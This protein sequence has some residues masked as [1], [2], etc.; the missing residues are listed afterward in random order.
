M[1]DFLYVDI[2][3][4]GGGASGLISGISAARYAKSKNRSQKIIIIE[5]ENRVGK[6]LLL[7]GNGKCNLTNKNVSYKFY[8]SNSSEIITS[9]LN[10]F[11]V[12]FI[13]DFF[14]S[15]GLIFKEDD[16]GRIYP[17]CNQ[18]SA[19]LDVIRSEVQRLKIEEF[20]EIDVF[21]IYK[22]KDYFI[23]D[24][25]DI[26]IKSKIIIMATGGKASQIS[27]N[28]NKI[29]TYMENLGHSINTI[30][31]SL[32]Q[33]RIDSLFL[34]S[35]KGMRHYGKVSVIADDNI[36]KSETGE[37]QFTENGLSGICIFS[38][39]RIISEYFVT[40]KI[41]NKFYTNI[42]VSV[43]LLPQYS[44]LDLEDMM[45]NRF[46]IKS[47]SSLEDF[48]TGA[49]NK[50]IALTFLKSIDITPLSKKAGC[51]TDTEKDK[52][53]FSLKNWIFKPTGTMPW[54]NAQVTAGGIDVR[55]FNVKT[56][57][58]KKVKGLFA[59][60]EI[61]DVDGDCGGFNLHWAWSSGC[62]AGMNAAKSNL[63]E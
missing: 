10:T 27:C 17:Y 18:A 19:V 38:I 15:L 26:K 48:F 7:T 20:C 51:L 57:E 29:Y 58:S 8:N 6:K 30:F 1:D 25:A 49:I 22:D 36:L 43:D 12:K 4:I 40:G 21:S 23:I 63:E 59:C 52:I 35:I 54:K 24:S 44:E 53:I 3:V 62:L 39:S 32:V 31:P 13:M 2:A 46:E 5:R 28:N 34:T 14:Y 55:E 11:T 61:L 37:L 47:D 50:R 33:I 41:K 16:Q 56:L 60:G 45:K 9:T 42:N